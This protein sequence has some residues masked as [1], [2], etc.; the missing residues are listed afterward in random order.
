MPVMVDFRAQS[1]PASDIELL[2][3]PFLF[4]LGIGLAWVL[5]LLGVIAVMWSW[6]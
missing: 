3:T 6:S 1:D 5:P 4:G 2:S